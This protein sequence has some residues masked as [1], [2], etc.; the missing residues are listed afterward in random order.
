MKFIDEVTIEVASGH[1]GAGSVHFLRQKYMPKMGPDGGDGGRG[2]H[3]YFEATHDLQ[4]LLDF[5]FRPD[6]IAPDGEDG[7]GAD[8]NGRDGLDLV[9]KVP[10]GTLIRDADT[11]QFLADLVEP[12]RR[13]LMQRGGKGGLGNMNFATAVRQAPDFAQPGRPGQQRRLRLELKLLADVGLVGFP[14]AGK[15]TLISRLS[16]ARPKIADYPFTT[17]VPNLGVARGKRLDYVIADVPGILEGASEGRGLGLQFLRHIER[18]RVLVFLLDLNPDTGRNLATEYETL[19]NEVGTFSEELLGHKRL[20]AVNKVD[21]FTDNVNDEV[22]QAFLEERGFNEL[23]SMCEE[24]GTPLKL[25]SAVSGVG[26][27]ALTTDIEDAL[28]EL[29]PRDYRN[30]V[31][32]TIE[33]GDSSLFASP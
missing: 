21:A 8:C 5:K 29:G 1:G 24:E 9:V 22:F 11:D 4:S 12:G 18:T 2:G 6:Y 28:V 27:E 33:L 17:L 15:S 3:V 32:E 7:S 20:V 30:Q 14:N 31:T 23:Q 26:L 16:A 10:V 19:L 25:V 13:I